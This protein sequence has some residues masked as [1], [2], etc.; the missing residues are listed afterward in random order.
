MRSDW[1]KIDGVIYR[2]TDWKRYPDHGPSYIKQATDLQT[3]ILEKRK[4]ETMYLPSLTL[5]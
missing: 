3:T 2:W 4:L 1:S 5:L